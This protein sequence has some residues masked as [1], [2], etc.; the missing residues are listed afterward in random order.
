MPWVAPK[1]YFDK[2]EGIPSEDILL[3]AAIQSSA[4]FWKRDSAQKRKN[5]ELFSYRGHNSFSTRR[6]TVGY[7]ATVSFI[8]D[9]I[10]RVV[11]FF[12]NELAPA[13][14]RNTVIVFWSDHGFHLGEHGLWGKYTSFDRATRVPFGI[15]PSK[16]I[17]KAHPLIQES[18]GGV[19]KAPVEAVDI[20]P[21]V[22]ELCNIPLVH[23]QEYS[24][25]S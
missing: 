15:V 16:N 10:A 24:G 6:K 3:Q 1:S 25:T 22:A 20:Y 13:V 4:R 8:D 7:L 21:T 18:V 19:V 2:Y 9:Q 5:Q 12:D 17:L 14:Q 23:N 11:D